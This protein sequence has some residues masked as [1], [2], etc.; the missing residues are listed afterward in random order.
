MK[1]LSLAV[2]T[3][4]LVGLASTMAGAQQATPVPQLVLR[5]TTA[6]NQDV[7]YWAGAPYSS[8]A[9]ISIA[10]ANHDPHIVAQ[11]FTCHGG[12]WAQD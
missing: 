1:R 7:C 10:G 8:G 11:Y 6:L 5:T 2:I 4:C 9:R 3:Y 12:T